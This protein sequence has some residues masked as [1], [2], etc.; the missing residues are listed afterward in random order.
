[1]GNF[2]SCR[3]CNAPVKATNAAKHETQR[4]PRRP[5]KTTTRKTGLRLPVGARAQDKNELE[6]SLR[7]SKHRCPDCLDW[8]PATQMQRHFQDH[9]FQDIRKRAPGGTASEWQGCLHCADLFRG[10]EEMTKH[11][12][13]MHPSAKLSPSN[14]RGRIMSPDRNSRPAVA[15]PNIP[16][17]N[18]IR[19]PDPAADLLRD[20]EGRQQ[21]S[22]D[23]TVRYAHNYRERGR[24]GSHSAHDDFSDES[25]SDISKC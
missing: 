1:M 23:A 8:V 11:L 15:P 25:G 18:N 21:P 20:K 5:R 22:L 14:L 9:R 2:I 16:T 12:I 7:S 19:I 17:W 13:E 10:Q 4:C 6:Y 24:A 3:Y